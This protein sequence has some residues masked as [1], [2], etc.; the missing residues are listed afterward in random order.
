M[1]QRFP[2]PLDRSAKWIQQHRDWAKDKKV[3]LKCGKTNDGIILRKNEL[4]LLVFGYI[5]FGLTAG[6]A[7]GC[8]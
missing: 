6:W 4:M 8:G 7:G 1:S 5:I 2:R 3:G